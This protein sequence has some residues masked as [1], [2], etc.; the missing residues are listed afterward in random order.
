MTVPKSGEHGK[1]SEQNGIPSNYARLVKLAGWAAAGVALVLIIVKSLALFITGS[2][3]ILASLLDSVMDAGASIINLL[4]IRY[5]LQPP[6]DEHRFG[7]GKAESLAGLVQ[8]AFIA[9][10][11]LILLLNGIDSLIHPKPL[12]N[13]SVGLWVM[14]FSIVITLVLVSFQRWVIKQT[15]SM[16]IKADSLHYWSDLLMNSAVV[17]ALFLTQLGYLWFDGLMAIVIALYIFHGAWHIA[18]DSI[19]SLLDRELG[20]DIQS[21]ILDLAHSVPGVH[22]VH[23][24]RTRQSGKTKILQLHLELQDTLTLQQAH[25][26]SDQVESKLLEQWPESD[27]IIHQ[28][29]LSELDMLS[30]VKD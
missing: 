23:D 8:A 1:A 4:A 17:M 27:I 15:D 16:V 9:G 7:H 28:D 13:T 25:A 26:I 18:Y 19:Q 3:S 29:P 20:E 12:L 30:N 21:K 24:L 11:S 22:G 14:V 10:S 2:V 6:D 5:A